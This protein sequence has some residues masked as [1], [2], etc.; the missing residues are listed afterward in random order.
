MC[1]AFDLPEQDNEPERAYI[2]FFVTEVTSTTEATKQGK[3]AWPFDALP[4]IC[5]ASRPRSFVERSGLTLSLGEQDKPDI[6]HIDGRANENDVLIYG[7]TLMVSKSLGVEREPHDG[8]NHVTV[9]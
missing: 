3:G 4:T 1:S 5:P 7:S 8:G 9:N 2:S 6:T